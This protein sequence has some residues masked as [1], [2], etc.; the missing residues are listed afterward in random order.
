MNNKYSTRELV[1]TA[2]YA[3]LFMAV[4]L[5][6]NYFGLLKMPNGGSLGLS[7][8]ILLLASYQLGLRKGLVVS[9]T[10]VALQFVTGQMYLGTGILGFFLDYILGFG[11]YGVAVAFPN[12]NKFY[13]GVLVTNLIRFIGST[14]SGVLF[15]ETPIWGSILYNSTYMIPTAIVGLILVP[16]INERLKSIN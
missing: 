9:L 3:A 7:S 13:S 14:I 2:M 16:L 5:I 15:Y 12:F 4:E 1:L 10:S 8:I 11:I 6:Q